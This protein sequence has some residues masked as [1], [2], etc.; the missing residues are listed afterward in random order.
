MFKMIGLLAQNM[1]TISNSV[2]NVIGW[3]LYDNFNEHKH[4][5]FDNE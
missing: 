4:L 5:R 2:S 3:D 1:L